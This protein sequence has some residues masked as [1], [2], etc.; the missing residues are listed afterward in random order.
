[1]A[2]MFSKEVA[3]VF[4]ITD[5]RNIA[6]ILRNGLHSENSGRDDPD[7]VSIGN[8]DLIQ[9]RASR[10]VLI[11]P[12]GTLADY[13][14]FYF[15]PYS[16]MMYKITTGHHG[17]PRKP[18]SEIAIVVS[19]LRK[20]AE[21]SVRFVFTDRHAYTRTARFF[22]S[23][24]DLTAIDWKILR[25]RD[26]QRDHNDPGKTSRY[27]AEA[28]FYKELPLEQLVGIVC[29]DESTKTLLEAYRRSASVEIKIV[30][31]P[32]WYFN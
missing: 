10:R 31:R 2:Q 30:V 24:D 21:S 6:W 7:Y 1:M 16:I 8:Q 3:W 18:N 29:Y 27:Q 4:R 26:F 15:T 28:L 19:S 25:S 5:V 13:I 17:I 22:S 11:T 20:I 14:P 32:Q 9:Y 12:H 23:T